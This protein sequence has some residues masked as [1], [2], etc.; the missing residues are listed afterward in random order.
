MDIAVPATVGK[1]MDIAVPA[2]VGDIYRYSCARHSDKD[3]RTLLRYVGT[4]RNF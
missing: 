4:V 3:I 2:T 1:Y